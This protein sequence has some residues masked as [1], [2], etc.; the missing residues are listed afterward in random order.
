MKNKTLTQV[1]WFKINLTIGF[2]FYMIYNSYFGWN[3]TPIN[4]YEKYC[5]VIWQV[6]LGFTIAKALLAI[7]YFIEEVTK[8]INRFK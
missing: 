1:K 4:E 6:F 3:K 7:T 5:D 8:H 2:T